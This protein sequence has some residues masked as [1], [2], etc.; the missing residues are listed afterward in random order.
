MRKG[1]RFGHKSHL[2]EAATARGVWSAWSLLPLYELPG[3][4]KSVSKLNA[5]QTLRDLLGANISLRN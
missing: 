4:L 2:G 3:R 1:T 5:L